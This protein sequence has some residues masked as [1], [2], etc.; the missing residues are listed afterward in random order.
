MRKSLVVLTAAALLVPAVTLAG[1]KATVGDQTLEVAAA[2][3]PNKAGGSRGVNLSFQL[4]YKSTDKDAQIKETTK[5]ITIVLPKGLT[6]HPDRRPACKLSVMW[7]EGST[8]CDP[9]T[10]VGH[11]TGTIDAR[12]DVPSPV[13]GEVYVYNGIHDVGLDGPPSDPTAPALVIEVRSPL[14]TTDMPFDIHGRRLQLDYHAPGGGFPP[15]VFHIRTLRLG[16]PLEKGK[17]PYVTAPPACTGSW[18]FAMTITNFDG[19]SI[20]ARHAVRCRT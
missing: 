20:T 5:R 13:D 18:P 11:G 9:E 1:K 4:A 8:H 6:L 15:Q 10:V 14:V 19:P 3:A 2:V 7:N 12:P 16:I 17:Q